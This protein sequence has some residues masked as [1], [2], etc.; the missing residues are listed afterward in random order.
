MKPSS[1]TE[2]DTLSEA[3]DTSGVKDESSFAFSKFEIENGKIG[4]SDK[5]LRYP[6][7][8]TI[9]NINMTT[10][11]D[12]K[13]PDW[14]DVGISAGL[15]GTG[16]LKADFA[17]N[18]RST[19]DL[20][21]SM[22]VVQF[23]M[24]DVDSYFRHYFGFP[25]T[26]GRMNFSSKNKLRANS[27]ISNNSIFFRKFKLD[28][29]TEDKTEYNIPL[30]LALGVMSDKDGIIDLKAPVE[31]K[32]E[33]VKVG[34]LRKIIFHTIGTLFVKAA[35]SPVNMISDLFKVDPESLKEI[36]LLL[37]DP[38]PDKK[39]METVDVLADILN[40]KPGLNV[41]LIYCI[42]SLADLQI[43]LPT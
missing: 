3:A 6:F 23:R 29:K 10:V 12:P 32:G 43:H 9:D 38:S 11:P 31:M 18:P 33:D 24:K 20:D 26:S 39:N 42:R 36:H 17:L 28:K 27:L 1:E 30:R 22:S 2:A 4:I 5:T 25:V 14:I 7:E 37:N 16:T 40:K 34:N 41:D 35:V 13:I 15:N 8:Y 19:S 21:I